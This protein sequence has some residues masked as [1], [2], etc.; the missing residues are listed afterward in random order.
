LSRAPYI[1]PIPGT[2]HRHRLEENAA[3][4]SLK[5]SADTEDALLQ[6]FAPGAASPDFSY[7]VDFRA[8]VTR[9][10]TEPI[11]RVGVVD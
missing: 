4:M 1:V 8:A 10:T 2:S 7:R 11:T 5:I 6:V 3:A 9:P